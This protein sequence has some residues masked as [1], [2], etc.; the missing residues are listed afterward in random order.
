[1]WSKDIKLHGVGGDII[2]LPNWWAGV[3]SLIQDWR[4]AFK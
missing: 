2:K 1:M 4:N 3:G